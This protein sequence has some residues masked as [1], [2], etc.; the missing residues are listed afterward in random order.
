[1]TRSCFTI[2]KDVRIGISI[3]RRFLL[4]VIKFNVR[5]IGADLIKSFIIV[6]LALEK[7]FTFI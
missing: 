3:R 6:L 4:R 1:M 7:G 5:A 2:I